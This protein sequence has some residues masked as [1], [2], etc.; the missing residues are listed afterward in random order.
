MEI[1]PRG[2]PPLE[3]INMQPPKGGPHLE[4]INIQPP[5]KSPP[6]EFINQRGSASR[7]NFYGSIVTN[8]F[9]FNKMSY[10]ETENQY[11]MYNVL[12]RIILNICSVMHLGLTSS[13]WKLFENAL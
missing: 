10:L 2:R 5:K 8:I 9:S 7:D 3:F 4:F 1:V 13:S 12:S 11:V 6:L